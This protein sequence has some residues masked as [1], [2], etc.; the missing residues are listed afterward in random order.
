LIGTA[1]QI[2]CLAGAYVINGMMRS[3]WFEMP[4]FIAVYAVVDAVTGIF[5]KIIN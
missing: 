3:S 2:S 1:L 4:A 5:S